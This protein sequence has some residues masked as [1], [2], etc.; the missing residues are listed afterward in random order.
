MGITGEG[1]YVGVETAV[2]VDVGSDEEVSLALI[3]GV[4]GIALIVVCDWLHPTTA[5]T[6]N[7]YINKLRSNLRRFIQSSYVSSFES[8]PG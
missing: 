6:I 7:A 2:V 1:G 4:G 3:G 5:S 8:C